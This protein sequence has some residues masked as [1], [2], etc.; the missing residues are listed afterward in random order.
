MKILRWL[1]PTALVLVA[2]I[3]GASVA[4]A[5]AD[6]ASTTAEPPQ[7]V[8]HGFV[9]EVIAQGA[10]AATQVGADGSG[11][12]VLKTAKGDV[13]VV[14]LPPPTSSE[15]RFKAPGRPEKT[16][17]TDILKIGARV[18]V[19]ARDVSGK[20]LAVQVL[21]KPEK[22]PKPTT[23]AVVEV[24]AEKG[25]VTVAT[26]D[27]KQ[28]TFKL[29]EGATLPEVGEVIALFRGPGER[30][31]DS[32]AP[33]EARGLVKSSEVWKRLKTH[34]EQAAAS[35][36]SDPDK[37]QLKARLM[38]RLTSVMQQAIDRH[39]QVLDRIAEKAPA[40]AKE[41]LA[42]ARER[43]LNNKAQK[44]ETIQKAKERIQ[45]IK[46]KRQTPGATPAGTPAAKGKP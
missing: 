44:L 29:P 30:D 6:P 17:V 16:P 14:Q 10:G 12:L 46:Q 22:E 28:R 18:A 21:V 41:V 15:Y 26:D 9:G 33:V 36:E 1:I 31:D 45:E 4:S 43:Y 24:N 38:E 27:G 40:K 35:A 23:G 19:L 20:W 5:F 7:Q 11:T 2:A 34:A 8:H 32:G 42:Q 3:L 25:T 13:V 37:A 39:L